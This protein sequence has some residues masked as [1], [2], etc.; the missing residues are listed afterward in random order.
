MPRSYGRD[1]RRVLGLRDAPL[2]NKDPVELLVWSA[3]PAAGPGNWADPY[4]VAEADLVA[5]AARH[6]GGHLLRL[7]V[8]AGEAFAVGGKAAGRPATQ[9]RYAEPGT[10]VLPVKSLSRTRVTA[11][12]DIDVAG[13][14][15]GGYYLAEPSPASGLPRV[16]A[17]QEHTLTAG[18]L[19]AAY[20]ALPE[21]VRDLLGMTDE[22]LGQHVSG[23]AEFAGPGA[24]LEVYLPEV[25]GNPQVTELLTDIADSLDALGG[26]LNLT[27]I[28]AINDMLLAASLVPTR[29]TRQ[30]A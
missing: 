3:E 19:L 2:V 16:P 28:S 23:L 6:S 21:Q 9:L 22:L 10:F 20:H 24:R 11:V 8:P 12:Y 25:F 26:P 7:L 17:G 4:L 13:Q 27:L 29:E 14:L 18:Q 1:E 15:T 5:A 30:A